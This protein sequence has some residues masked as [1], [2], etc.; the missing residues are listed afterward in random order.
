MSEQDLL[1]NPSV[2]VAE[3]GTLRITGPE[4]RSWLNGLLTCDV[5]QA[6]GTTGVWGLLLNKRGKIVCDLTLVPDASGLW[7]GSAF[8]S[9]DLYELLDSYLVMEDAEL[10]RISGHVWL[11]VQGA[12]SLELLKQLPDAVDAIAKV[13]WTRHDA[14][15][16]VLPADRRDQ[17]LSW[18]EK[19]FGAEL[20]DER[21]WDRYR[22]RVGLP[23]FGVDFTAEDNPHEA[24]LERRTVDWSKGCYLGQEVVCMQDMRGKVKRRL[25]RLAINAGGAVGSSELSAGAP[26]TDVSGGQEVGRVTTA[27]SPAQPGEP[28]AIARL[29][30]PFFEAGTQVSIGDISARVL[31]LMTELEGSEPR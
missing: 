16:L 4:A 10:E 7:L 31:T 13:A 15:A 22:V 19:D 27:L 12:R 18:L 2:R 5:E 14:V 23:R 29:K 24:G 21:A 25:A 1:P 20:M 30:A 3:W 9:A 8:E 26:V 6:V 17:C 11:T 28:V